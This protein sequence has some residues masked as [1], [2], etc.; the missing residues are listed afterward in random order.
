MQ[1]IEPHHSSDETEADAASES[2]PRRR[3]RGIYL[4]PNLFTTAAL[5]S[6]FYAIIA[7]QTGRFS[8]AAVAVFIAMILDAVDG[9]VARMTNTQSAFGAQYDSLADLI[10]FGLAP[11]LVMYQWSLFNMNDV[12][13]G[14]AKLGWL[15]AFF[16]TAAA[17]MRLARFNVS[18]GTADKR[19]FLGLPSPTAA[20]LMIGTVWVA[21]DLGI[22]GETLMVPA[23]IITIAAGA[24]MVSNVL[25]PSF[26]QIDYKS[27]VPFL[28]VLVMVL[29]VML[30]AFDPPKTL[31]LG[32]LVYTL[33]G[34][35]IFVLRL[36]KRKNRRD[37]AGPE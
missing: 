15:A 24:L 37:S 26:K 6:G 5:F 20:A 7:A 18:L 11:A 34:P 22:S 1:S 25:Y 12:G 30:L 19:Y 8:A 33:S 29:V 35:V 4:L 10:S 9:R 16:Y 14:W 21:T 23:F 31:F 17:A 32:F 36:R 2:A 3:S 13:W 27:R 28:G